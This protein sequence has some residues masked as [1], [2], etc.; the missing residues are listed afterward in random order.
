MND[1][2]EFFRQPTETITGSP[3]HPGT[4]VFRFTDSGIIARRAFIET[5]KGGE[6]LNL[7]QLTDIH[8]S[9]L[10][11]R[12]FE[13]KNPVVLS[14]YDGRRSSFNR[15]DVFRNLDRLMPL[16]PLFDRTFVTGDVIDYLT[17]GAVEYIKRYLYDRHPEILLVPGGHDVSRKCQGKVDDPSSLESRQEILKT[18]WKQDLYYHSEVLADKVM[19]V[20]LNNG[21][22][23]YYSHQTEKLKADIQR[24]RQ[25][26]LVILIF[27]HEPLCTRNESEKSV[28]PLRV[29]QTPIPRDYHNGRI[30]IG[31]TQT[32]GEESM[33]MYRLITESADVIKAV[34][35]GHMHNEVYTE[36]VGWDKTGDIAQR[37]MIPQYIL[38]AAAYDKGHMLMITIR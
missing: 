17:W 7:L 21:E 38:D 37:V 3:E 32:T 14:T 30:F 16:A 36:I 31:N 22:N 10:N 18:V 4:H 6:E 9:N 15:E 19:L 23:R 13:E 27:Q 1:I 12:D 8:L 34:F 29:S 5:K 24:A 26:N 25:E 35:C 2:N 28:V 11:L 20:L 33:E